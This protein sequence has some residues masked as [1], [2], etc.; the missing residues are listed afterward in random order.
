MNSVKNNKM[1]CKKI[2]DLSILMKWTIPLN[3][4]FLFNVL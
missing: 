4:N 1:N 3:L 2:I